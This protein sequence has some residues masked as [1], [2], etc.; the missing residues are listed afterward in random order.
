MGRRPGRQRNS[1]G[2]LGTT[3]PLT[4]AED[5]G[6]LFISA[7]KLSS[8]AIDDEDDGMMPDGDDAEDEDRVRHI[9][10]NVPP[11][12]R[13]DTKSQQLFFPVHFATVLAETREGCSLLEHSQLW[14]RAVACVMQQPL[15]PNLVL[16]DSEEDSS[17]SDYDDAYRFSEADMGAAVTSSTGGLET[18]AAVASFSSRKVSRSCKGSGGGGGGGG[19]GRL[20]SSNNTEDFDIEMLHPSQFLLRG[21]ARN[22]VQEFGAAATGMVGGAAVGVG[23]GVSMGAS[24]AGVTCGGAQVLVQGYPAHNGGTMQPGGGAA[25]VASGG[26]GGVAAAG[27]GAGAGVAGGAAGS[28]SLVFAMGAGDLHRLEVDYHR[29]LR[30][31]RRGELNAPGQSSSLLSISR[32]YQPPVQRFSF[33]VVGDAEV[34]RESILCICAVGSTEEGFRLLCSTGSSANTAATTTTTATG[35]GATTTTTTSSA[36]CSPLVMASS[37]LIKRLIALSCFCSTISVRNTSLLGCSMLTRCSS[38]E[39]TL[40]AAGFEVYRNPSAYVSA[41]GVPYAVGYAFNRRSMYAY[42]SRKPMQNSV[43]NYAVAGGSVIPTTGSGKRKQPAALLRAA[44]AAATPNI[45]L[46]PNTAMPSP[47]LSTLHASVISTGTVPERVLELLASLPCSVSREN[48]KTA[49]KAILERKPHYFLQPGVRQ[50]CLALSMRYRMRLEERQFIA[51]LL[52]SAR[53]RLSSAVKRSQ[54]FRHIHRQNIK[55]MNN[56]N[57][58]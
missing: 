34:L 57:K 22:A 25:T 38:G 51:E 37:E 52:D 28:P 18:A 13:M 40:R 5:S 41:T 30:H 4:A 32:G 36:P 46:T 16:S 24:L 9:E 56:N 54:S 1:V 6:A 53:L 15:P 31:L 10:V 17:D 27:M 44:S 35:S 58:K 49:L 33:D 43:A 47:P 21:G 50:Y 39:R 45:S 48:S 14:Q 20:A 11:L 2:M 19:G 3:P 7:S 55:K 23:G 8:Y 12:I 26:G 29:R 42:T